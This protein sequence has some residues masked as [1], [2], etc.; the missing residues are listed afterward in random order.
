MIELGDSRRIKHQRM[1]LYLCAFIERRMSSSA[2]LPA[3]PSPRKVSTLRRSSTNVNASAERP[4][5][6]INKADSILKGNTMPENKRAFLPVVKQE[7]RPTQYIVES[8]TNRSGNRK[9]KA[10]DTETETVVSGESPIVAKRKSVN[11]SKRITTR[12]K[13][14]SDD[15][16]VSSKKANEKTALKEGQLASSDKGTSTKSQKKEIGTQQEQIETEGKQ[17]FKRKTKTRE[18]KDAEAIPL[19]ARTTGLRMFIGMSCRLM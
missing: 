17:K 11:R 7:H 18:E 14:M 19:A 12:V 8:Q 10:A 1:L 13:E 4:E 3:M 2:C 16:N 6:R 5:S 9:R 15:D